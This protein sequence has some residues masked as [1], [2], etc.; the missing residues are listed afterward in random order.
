MK[1]YTL[2]SKIGDYVRDIEVD[3]VND[4]YSSGCTYRKDGD[5]TEEINQLT[6]RVERDDHGNLYT[7]KKYE[8]I[9]FFNS[10]V[11]VDY[12]EKPTTL[13]FYVIS[14]RLRDLLDE[15]ELPEHRY[16]EIKLDID[17]KRNSER[18]YI[19]QIN[20]DENQFLDYKASS[21]YRRERIE[22]GIYNVIDY[23]KGE[24]SSYKVLQFIKEELQQHPYPKVMVLDKTLDWFYYKPYSLISEKAQQL[25]EKHNIIGMEVIPIYQQR[26]TTSRG[27]QHGYAIAYGG[28]EII[29][30]GQSSLKGIDE[31]TFPKAVQD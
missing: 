31:S 18:Y 19:L 27:N 14:T 30:D 8:A 23:Q 17:G 28:V 12:S 9:D 20:L 10:P 5:Y 1:L 16:Y 11:I 21:F 26:S 15:L 2:E 3:N 6:F 7:N 22:R 29:M 25:F 4:P 13:D 24:V